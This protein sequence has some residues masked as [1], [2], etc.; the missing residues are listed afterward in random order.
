MIKG[1]DFI[2]DANKEY[3]QVDKIVVGCNGKEYKVKISS[4]IKDSVV[5]DIVDEILARSE[6]CKKENIKFDVVMSIYALII[7]HLTDIKFSEYPNTKKQFAH[8]IDMLKAMIDL[9]ILE[10]ILKEFNIDEIKKIQD[11]FN[12]YGNTF[13]KINDNIISQSLKDD[14]VGDI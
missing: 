3:E 5:M 4:K 6:M 10:P 14:E 2:K 12:K 8:E 1:I 9:Q 13:R 7:K 11:A